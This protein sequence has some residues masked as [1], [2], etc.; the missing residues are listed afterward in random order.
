MNVTALAGI[1][2]TARYGILLLPAA[3]AGPHCGRA[4]GVH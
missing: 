2:A 4:D 3:T 1:D